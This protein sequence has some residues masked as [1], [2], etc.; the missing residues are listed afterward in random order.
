MPT[1]RRLLVWLV[2]IISCAAFTAALRATLRGERSGALWLVAIVSVPAL[3]A[4]WRGRWRETAAAIGILLAGPAVSVC[5]ALTLRSWLP[6]DSPLL[7]LPGVFRELA[8][9]PVFYLP[10]AFG[11]S[12]SLLGLRFRPPQAS[13]RGDRWSFAPILVWALCAN[14]GT[15]FYF[16]SGRFDYAHRELQQQLLGLGSWVLVISLALTLATTIPTLLQD[17]RSHRV[18]SLGLTALIPVLVALVDWV[19]FTAVLRIAWRIQSP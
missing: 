9:S 18:P 19:F 8:Y 1:Q 13:S 12:W 3:W 2:A 16:L 11:V 10:V 7:S 17:R 6:D 14:R 5:L 15:E 4:Q